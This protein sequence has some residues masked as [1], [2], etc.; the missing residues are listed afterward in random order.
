M[1]FHRTALLAGLIG[2]TV[3]AAALT[4]APARA[5]APSLA[6]NGPQAD[7]LS[8]TT[9]S[10]ATRLQPRWNTQDEC[11]GAFRGSA[12]LYALNSDGSVGRRISPVVTNVGAPFGGTLLG[13]VGQLITAGTDVGDG[14]TDEWVVA[15]L[16]RA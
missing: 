4:A 13:P 12:A 3:G 14:G 5:A 6:A 15:V 1:G 9:A 2:V 8:L 7:N 16:H 10:G 11:P